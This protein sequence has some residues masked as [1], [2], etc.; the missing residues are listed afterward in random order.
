MSASEYIRL[1]LVALSR[2]APYRAGTEA[3]MRR[4]WMSMSEAE[5]V[6]ARSFWS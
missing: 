3:R 2:P 5:R 6:V 4:V 1:A